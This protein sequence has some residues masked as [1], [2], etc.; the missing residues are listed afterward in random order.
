MCK[1]PEEN[2]QEADRAALIQALVVGNETAILVYTAFGE[3]QYVPTVNADPVVQTIARSTSYMKEVFANDAYANVRISCQNKH[4]MCSLWAS[5]DECN[6][7]P[8]YMT[9]SCAPSCQTCEQISYDYRCPFDKD[10]PTALNA[11]DL[12]RM[13]ERNLKDYAHFTPTVLSRPPDGPWVVQFDTFATRSE[14]E[15]LIEYGQKLGYESSQTVG[16]VREDG[17]VE[18]GIS[19]NPV[20]TSTNAWC[21]GDCEHDPIVEPLIQRIEDVLGIPK[22]NSEYLQ[23]RR[24]LWLFFRHPDKMNS[25]IS[26]QTFTPCSF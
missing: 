5:Q 17:S 23:V 19:N 6:K 25:H 14:C 1:V 24:N 7:N 13:F 18:E 11:G 8:S 15:R 20:R 26:P 22:E 21:Q 4:S 3:A 2:P 9:I 16:R 12:D 10:A